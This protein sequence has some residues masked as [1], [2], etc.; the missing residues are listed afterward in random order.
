MFSR[1]LHGY[2]FLF[3]DRSNSELIYC[4][5]ASKILSIS[6]KI[7][8]FFTDYTGMET[9]TGVKRNNCRYIA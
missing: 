4:L 6:L 1:V 3:L 7:C 2:K 9:S 5:P 8:S